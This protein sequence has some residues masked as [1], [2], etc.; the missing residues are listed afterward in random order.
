MKEAATYI[1]HLNRKM[2][3]EVRRMSSKLCSAVINQPFRFQLFFFEDGKQKHA[4]VICF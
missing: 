2:A 4:F 3:S 1:V